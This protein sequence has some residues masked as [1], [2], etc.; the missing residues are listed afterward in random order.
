MSIVDAHTHLGLQ[1]FL[2]KPIPAEKRSKPAFKDRLENRWEALIDA[3][4]RNGVQQAV[5]FPYPMAEVD[6]DLAN[7]YVFE[8]WERYPDRIIPFALVGDDAV[9]WIAR[10]A[11]G[12]K[13][14]FL[15][16]PQRFELETIYPIIAEA[17]L[18]LIAHLETRAIVRGVE[19]ILALA[20][21][22]KVIVAHM[23][24]CEP[25]T[26][27]GVVENLDALAKYPGVFFETSTVRDPDVF[28]QAVRKVG[29]ERICF[30][31]DFPFNSHLN[32]DPMTTELQF[33]NSAGLAQRDLEKI[34]ES[35]I[36]ELTRGHS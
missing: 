10:G 15:L 17:G 28:R 12:F 25:N 1:R 23:G 27:L 4:D 24:R 11:R 14:H 29:S 5:S 18:P 22:L 35:N 36:L 26:G 8:A 34:M 16:E 7:G 3:M 21:T 30:G 6:S 32:A 2:V 31:S 9:Q 13:Q 33:M 20:P 19:A